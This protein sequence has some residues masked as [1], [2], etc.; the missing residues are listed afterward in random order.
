MSIQKRP[1]PRDL[2]YLKLVWGRAQG[3]DDQKIVTELEDPDID[4]PQVLYRSLHKDN[5]PVCPTC[6]EAPVQAGHCQEEIPKRQPRKSGPPRDLPPA[7]AAMS[8]F[9]ERIEAL[10]RAVENLPY[11]V[12]TSQGGRFVGTSVYNDP[13]LLLRADRSEEEWQNLCESEGKDPTSDRILFSGLAMQSPVGATHAPP[14]PLVLLIAA[15]ALADG[16]MGEL[17]RTLHPEPSEVDAE[18]LSRYL[19][20]EKKPHGMDGL[21]RRAEQIAILVR[22]GTVGRGAPPPEISPREHNT[23]CHITHR[24]DHGWSDAQIY[25]ELRD[26]GFTKEDVSRLGSLRLRWPE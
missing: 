15:Y 19:H 21:M 3:A 2:R 12:E 4:S 7:S 16:D 5:Y 10:T 26:Q 6:G 23:A 22:G 9:Q 24:R 14:R 25:E 20:A 18:Q 17:L 11:L 1:D 8:L 13:I